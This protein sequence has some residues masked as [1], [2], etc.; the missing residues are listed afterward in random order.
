MDL[1]KAAEYLKKCLSI[2]PKHVQGLVSMGNL[3]FETG[4]S[5]HASKYHTQALKYNPKEI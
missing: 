1:T 4:H 3:L 5:K 2:N